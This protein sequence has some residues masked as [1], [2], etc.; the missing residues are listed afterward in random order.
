L[1]Y[2]RTLKPKLLSLPIIPAKI[3]KYNAEL[4]IYDPIVKAPP[5]DVVAQAVPLNIF[6][7][8]KSC[9]K[10]GS[11]AVSHIPSATGMAPPPD[12]Y[13]CRE[14]GG[15][16]ESTSEVLPGFL[17]VGSAASCKQRSVLQLGITMLFNC[18][19]S[20]KGPPSQPPAYRCREA[21]L[22]D[23]PK[24]PDAVFS[25]EERTEL[26]AELE[27]LY[28]SIETHRVTPELAA[29]SDPAPKEYRGP[30]DKL[31]MPIKTAAD[32][33]VLRRPKDGEKPLYEPR[34]LL[35]S[36][37]GTDRACAGAAAYIIKQYGIT[38]DHAVHIVKA[39]RAATALSQA[40]LDLLQHWS[41]RYTLGL[42]ICVD[43]QA[44]GRATQE[45]HA[46]ADAAFDAEQKAREAARR[47]A[48]KALRDA[49]GQGDDSSSSDDDSI[50]FEQQGEE[51]DEDAQQQQEMM[52]FMGENSMDSAAEA[53]ITARR[54]LGL[55]A[56][57]DSLFDSFVQ[58][59]KGHMGKMLKEKPHEYNILSNVAT[60]LH[61]IMSN[62]VGVKDSI[63]YFRWSGL[64]D[65]ELSGR[66]LSDVTM[67]VL[68]QLLA[69]NDL[70]GRIRMLKLQSNLI[71][72]AALKAM[73]IA[74]YPEGHTSDDNYAF[75]D[76]QSEVYT[77]HSSDLMLLDL[78][79]NK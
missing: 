36:R 46:A 5:P 14:E 27:K 32:L 52:M 68:F 16:T 76:S 47:R 74:Y 61:K 38:V 49:T 43:C 19:S 33:K 72:S 70:I 78:S 12:L 31:G 44:N 3:G 13:K 42:L 64:V 67:S 7:V 23:R 39:G 66:L 53:V 28:D 20:M 22:K 75:D 29:K 2:H 58:L 9:F 6:D 40:Y 41:A 48:K 34:V 73:L 71:A 21:P 1:N 10:C 11:M 45:M 8:T 55:E 59:M 63:P 17:W 69:G 25:E 30:T 65:L 50:G 54:R 24:D 77:A 15:T 37:L 35:W 79:N 4:A 56:S 62:S 18:T 57:A 26:L 51:N 60:Y